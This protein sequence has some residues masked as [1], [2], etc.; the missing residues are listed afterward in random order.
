MDMTRRSMI[1]AAAGLTALGAGSASALALPPAKENGRRH[2]LYEEQVLA[3]PGDHGVQN[4]R[5][6]ALAVAPSG[7]L[8]AAYD[9]RPVGGDS[10][11][12]NSLWQRRSRDNGRTWEEPT[13]I[14]AGVESTEPGEK[15]GYSDPSYVVD[16]ETGTIFCFSVFSKDVGMWDSE[17]GNDDED[18]NIASATVATSHDDGESWEY[19]SLTTIVKPQDCRATFA[20]SGAGIQVRTG[21]YAGR[22]VQ[23]YA[24]W[25]RQADGSEDVKAY[26]LY[27]DD[28]GETWTMGTPVGTEMDENKV[29]ELS[30][31]TL[32]MNSRENVRTGRRWVALSHDG[33]GDLGGPAPRRVPR[34]SGQQRADHARVPGRGPGITQVQDPA[35]LPC[36][37]RARRPRQRHDRDLDRRR[38]HLGAQAGL[39]VRRLPVLGDHPDPARPVRSALRGRGRGDHLRAPR[40]ELDPLPLRGAARWARARGGRRHRDGAAALSLWPSAAR[41]GA[42]R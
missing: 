31:G 6:P 1:G 25:F 37:P 7:D 27:S 29:V 5:I 30:D 10:P 13:V 17:Y 21:P 19:R 3:A 40:H 20:S 8:L 9:K 26:S 4:F 39:P 22:L 33:G 18:R 42:Q 11:S 38:R 34:R 16:R 35:V 23:Q 24:G 15:L 28:H 2:G 36:R 12:P 32:M 14:R 41:Q